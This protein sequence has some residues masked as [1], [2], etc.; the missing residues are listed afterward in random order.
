MAEPE[1]EPRRVTFP[2]GL[3]GAVGLVLLV[4]S[5]VLRHEIDVTYVGSLGFGYAARA[6]RE[7]PRDGL[8]CMGDSLVKHGVAPR[9]LEDRLGRRGLNV[10]SVGGISPL[11]YVLLKRALDGGARPAAVLVDFNANMLQFDPRNVDRA[12]VEALGLW[13]LLQ[14]ARVDRDWCHLARLASW[15][16]LPSLRARGD[17]RD[18]VSFALQGKDGPHGK[19]NRVYLRN[20]EVNQGAWLL[21]KQPPRQADEQ[22][23]VAAMPWFTQPLNTVYLKRFLDL[24]SSRRVPVFWLIPPVHPGVQHGRDRL[25]LDAPYDALVRRCLTLY[26]NLTVID[27]RKSAYPASV[28]ADAAHLDVEGANAFSSDLAA[29][30]ADL[31]SGRVGARRWV[32]LPPYRARPVSHLVEDLHR[33]NAII[34]E[35]DRTRAGA[36]RLAA[37]AGGR[38]RR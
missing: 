14:L 11:T 15:R 19:V 28:F 23:G 1:K 38:L 10:A 9:V 16:A 29:T 5:W 17:I 35:R 7:A 30:L 12:L 22:P 32:E 21:G 37:G 20:W 18:W 8:L 31:S 3:A 2:W 25:N 26:P 36:A 24:A 34:T 27:A 13:D 4:E 6:V 33:S